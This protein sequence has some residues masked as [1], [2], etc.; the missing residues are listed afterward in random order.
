[1]W[2]WKKQSSKKKKKKQPKS[3]I[4][5]NYLEPR[6]IRCYQN[7]NLKDKPVR[8]QCEVEK[9]KTIYKQKMAWK[10]MLSILLEVK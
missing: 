6:M 10:K 7:L 9:N 1:M 4:S 5:K 3:I 2:I 8:N